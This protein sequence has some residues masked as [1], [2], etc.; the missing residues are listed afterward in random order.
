MQTGKVCDEA[1]TGEA[2]V[3]I[4]G[5]LAHFPGLAKQQTISFS[6]LATHDRQA[7]TSLADQANFF[8]CAPLTATARPDARTFT[9]S[10][11]IDGRSR[12]LRLAE[13]ISDPAM[14]KLVSILRRLSKQYGPQDSST[15][16]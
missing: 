12:E 7:L 5:G 2:R 13:P 15:K 10:L 3:Q 6:D 9:L 16:I 1:V 14:A 4:E 8:D 11:T